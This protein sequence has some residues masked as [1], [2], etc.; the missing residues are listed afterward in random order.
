MTVHLEEAKMEST[1]NADMV[2]S[3]GLMEVPSRAT[4]STGKPV[5]SVSSEPP[6]TRSLKVTGS[7]TAQLT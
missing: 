2:S 7:K 4:G 3:S 5:D 6:L 1:L